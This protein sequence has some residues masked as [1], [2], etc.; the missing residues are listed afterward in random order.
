M[1]LTVGAP[2]SVAVFGVPLTH[3]PFW[4]IC[5]YAPS[6]T[7]LSIEP[8][9]TVTPGCTKFEGPICTVG[10]FPPFPLFPLFDVFPLLLVLALGVPGREQAA[11]KILLKA[12]A[13]STSSSNDNRFL[14]IKTPTQYF[15]PQ[16]TPPP[17]YSLCSGGG[18]GPQPPCRSARCPRFLLFFLA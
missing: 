1:L 10:P 15:P 3:E 16:S 6:S 13:T 12:T 4:R 11:S 18:G 17:A 5:R 2:G 7:S 8:L 9:G 14:L